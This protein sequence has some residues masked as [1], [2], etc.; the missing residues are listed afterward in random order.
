MA[1]PKNKAPDRSE[2]RDRAGYIRPQRLMGCILA[3]LVWLS[4]G[5]PC[6]RSR[7]KADVACSYRDKA[8]RRRLKFSWNSV[9]IRLGEAGLDD[10]LSLSPKVRP[11]D[12]GESAGIASLQR[13]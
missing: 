4:N 7:P 8:N 10:F 13:V 2:A 3:S 5:E 1:R 9:I 11:Q 12:V 6:P